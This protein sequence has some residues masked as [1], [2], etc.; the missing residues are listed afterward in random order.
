MNLA[1]YI[2]FVILGIAVV[3]ALLGIVAPR[4]KKYRLV[5]TKVEPRKKR[6]VKSKSKKR[7]SVWI[8]VM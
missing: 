7:K 6:S 1:A 4:L 3:L 5:I 8:K 2:P